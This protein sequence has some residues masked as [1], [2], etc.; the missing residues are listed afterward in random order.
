M[1][2]SESLRHIILAWSRKGN[3]KVVQNSWIICWLI[4]SWLFF[5]SSSML[6][7]LR[8]F[9]YAQLTF[10]FSQEIQLSK[11]HQYKQWLEHISEGTLKSFISKLK[12][13]LSWNSISHVCLSRNSSFMPTVLVAYILRITKS[14]ILD[15][16]PVFTIYLW[17]LILLLCMYKTQEKY[18]PLRYIILG[19]IVVQIWTTVTSRIMERREYILWIY[20]ATQI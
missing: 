1:N 7:R 13:M 10:A 4:V 17:P 15:I 19:V 14:V 12:Y 3:S 9:W 20:F 11:F 6:F 5:V 18:Y 16:D 2:E 8:V